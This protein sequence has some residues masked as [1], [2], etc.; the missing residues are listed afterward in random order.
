MKIV[1]LDGLKSMNLT[2]LYGSL[3][4][5]NLM[6]KIRSSRSLNYLN[7]DVSGKNINAIH[8]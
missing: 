1:F 8:F 6:L 7:G 3:Y 2:I 5:H 4:F